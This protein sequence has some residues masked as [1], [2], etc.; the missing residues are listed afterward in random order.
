M[1][2]LAV[3][4]FRRP[5][6]EKDPEVAAFVRS[7]FGTMSVHDMPDA[8][9]AKFSPERAPAK[10]SIARYMNVLRGLPA[11]YPKNR[12]SPPRRR[13]RPAIPT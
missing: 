6:W 8:I 3:P 12:K 7:L 4:L 1:A 13:S 5:W 10:S 11:E 2:E 9:A